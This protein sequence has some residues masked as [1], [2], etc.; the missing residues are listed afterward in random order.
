MHFYLLTLQGLNCNLDT[1]FFVPMKHLWNKT[2]INLYESLATRIL[3]FSSHTIA[4]PAFQEIPGVAVVLVHSF[5][6]DQ[7]II[8]ESIWRRLFISCA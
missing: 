4:L 6:H 1:G 7:R 3:L 5:Q 2:T 8:H